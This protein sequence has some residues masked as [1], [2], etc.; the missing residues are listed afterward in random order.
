MET[1]L[2]VNENSGRDMV[3]RA[4]Q[5]EVSKLSPVSPSVKATPPPHKNSTSRGKDKPSS[6]NR[7]QQRCRDSRPDA[8][9]Q[10]SPSPTAKKAQGR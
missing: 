4:I 10:R 2:T 1:K 9:N 5:Q 6:K 7:K 3:Q 8:L